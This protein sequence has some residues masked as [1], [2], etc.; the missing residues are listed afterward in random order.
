MT[1]RVTLLHWG[2]V[3]LILSKEQKSKR[4]QGVYWRDLEGKDKSYFLRIR[5]DGKV[6]RIPIGKKS[7]GITEAFCNQEK[8][9]ILN[10][11]RFGEETALEL[12]KVKSEDPTFGELF[13]WYLEKRQLKSKLGS[14]AP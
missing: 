2:K 12:Q 8:A 11:H 7:E 4:Y 6:K 1:L 3:V 14:G 9:R 10:A 13:E 5:V